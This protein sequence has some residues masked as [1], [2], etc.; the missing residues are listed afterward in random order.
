MGGRCARCCIYCCKTL[1]CRDIFDDSIKEDSLPI[2]NPFKALYLRFIYN[3][4]AKKRKDGKQRVE[5]QKKFEKEM[6]ETARKMH[7]RRKR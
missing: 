4:D 7:S 5:A 2:K 6:K 1:Y 3:M